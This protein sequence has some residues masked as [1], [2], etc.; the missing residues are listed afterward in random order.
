MQRRVAVVTGA[1]TGVGL[2]TALALARAPHAFHVIL[3]C[4]SESRGAEAVEWLRSCSADIS[5]SVERLDLAD[6]E[7]VVRFTDRVAAAHPAGIH[8]VV[9]NAGIGGMD[10]RPEASADGADLVYRVNFVSHFV[11]VLR[12]LPL[13]ERGYRARLAA[14]SG[15]DG[16][17]ELRQY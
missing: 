2:Q 1:N 13:L 9:C 12:L 4:R 15:S 10:R 17:F 3:A 16:G 5:A 6:L 14:A 11:L 7:D 8:V